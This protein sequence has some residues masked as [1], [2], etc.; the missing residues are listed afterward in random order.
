MVTIRVVVALLGRKSCYCCIL[1]AALLY[2]ALDPS[3][4]HLAAVAYLA[5]FHSIP[6]VA[7]LAYLPV[8]LVHIHPLARHKAHLVVDRLFLDKVRLSQEADHVGAR[9][10]CS[11]LGA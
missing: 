4:G 10:S 8:V 7:G 1:E 6:V 2:L 9:S 11:C 3:L 5:R